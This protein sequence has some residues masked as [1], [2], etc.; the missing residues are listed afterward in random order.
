[1][2]KTTITGKREYLKQ[3]QGQ[4]KVKNLFIERYPALWILKILDY[5]HLNHENSGFK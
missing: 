4:D 1:M 2:Q 3:P 5:F